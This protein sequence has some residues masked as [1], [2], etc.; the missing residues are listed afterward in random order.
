MKIMVLGFLGSDVI[1]VFMVSNKWVNT[2][3]HLK[4]HYIGWDKKR[5]ESYKLGTVISIQT[6]I[7]YIFYQYIS[8]NTCVNIC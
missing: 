1:K 5:C 7:Y 4:T 3:D 8:T 6:N 2:I